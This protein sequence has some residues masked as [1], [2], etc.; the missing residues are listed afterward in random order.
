[1]ENE[2]H[3]Y[4]HTFI[5]MVN[6]FASLNVPLIGFGDFVDLQFFVGSANFIHILLKFTLVAGGFS[7]FSTY[8]YLVYYQIGSNLNRDSEIYLRIS[9]YP[10][11]LQKQRFESR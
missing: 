2:K 1:M 10:N 8:Q 11:A 4:T 3:L 6:R 7:V 9:V 5:P